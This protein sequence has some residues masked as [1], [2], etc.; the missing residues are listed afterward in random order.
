MLKKR[1]HKEK[2]YDV[3]GFELEFIAKEFRSLNSTC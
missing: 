1:Q 2:I 3:H